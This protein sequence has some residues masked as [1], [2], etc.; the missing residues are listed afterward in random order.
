VPAL[1]GLYAPRMPDGHARVAGTARQR[2]EDRPRAVAHREELPRLLPLQ[3]DAQIR[4]EL[5]RPGH[6]E[7][8]QDLAYRGPR[9]AGEGR[10]VDSVMG[11]VAAPA[12]RHQ[13][14]RAQRPRAV[15]RD[16]GA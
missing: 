15:E 2:V 10:L 11:D 16:D 14:L 5:H 8:P 9:G 13:D 7:P 1:D 4:E 3:G 6:V 12:P